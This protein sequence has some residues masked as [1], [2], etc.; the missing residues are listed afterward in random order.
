LVNGRPSVT[1]LK[2]AE[3]FGKRHAHIIRDIQRITSECP[4]D[5]TEPNFGLSYYTDETGRVLPM[6]I[7]HRDRF[8]LLVMSYTGKKA[9]QIK[10]AYIAALCIA[11]CLYLTR[12]LEQCAPFFGY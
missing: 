11:Y 4:T 12:R 3:H 7:I 10:L 6:F 9:L 1:S 8:T 5:F 2:I